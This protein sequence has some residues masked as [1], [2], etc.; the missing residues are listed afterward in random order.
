M[1]SLN[2]LNKIFGPKES[3]SR[4]EIDAYKNQSGDLHDVELKASSS[5]FDKDAL[6]GW[7]DTSITVEKGM[8]N[9]DQKMEAFIHSSANGTSKKITRWSVSLLA[10]C[11]VILVLFIY[12]GNKNLTDQINP[13]PELAE[14]KTNP[15]EEIDLYNQIPEEKQL[16]K[17][18]LK[19]PVLET[20]VEEEKEAEAT[21]PVLSDVIQETTHSKSRKEFTEDESIALPPVQSDGNIQNS[22]AK[23]LVYNQAKEFYIFDLKNV[24]YR[25]YRDRPLKT[26]SFDLGTPADQE[27]R[28]F[29]SNFSDEATIEPTEVTYIDYLTETANEFNEGNYK[30]ALKKYL[31]I[32]AN[33]PDDVNANFYGGLCYFNLGQFE[34]S[35]QLFDKSYTI[36]YGNFREE[37]MWFTARAN[38]ELE[39]NIK[40]RGLLKKIIKEDGFYKAQAQELLI[41]IK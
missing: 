11:A 33:Y 8:E 32:L 20:T 35:I 39:N 13:L 15:I 4:Q 30:V 6:E 5:T 12:Q 22:S 17:K 28:A 31:V 29:E 37:A 14:H 38:Y 10:A 3:L 40:T 27:A 9:L 18:D 21:P 19:K 36:G 26:T 25:A 7:E 1:I 16:S 2:L 34:Q 24:D 41:K 23:T